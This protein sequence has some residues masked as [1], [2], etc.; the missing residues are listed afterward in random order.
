MT[1]SWSRG[2]TAELTAYF[3]NGSGQLTDA[4]PVLVDILDP[5]DVVVV[6]DATPQHPST[7]TYTYD[8]E[9]PT[10]ATLGVWSARWTGV[11]FSQPVGPTEEPFEVVPAGEV[12][13]QGDFFASVADLAAY[14]D[15]SIAS[16]DPR[17]LLALELATGLIQAGC[18]HRIFR[19]NDDEKVL[20]GT[21]GNRLYLPEPPV[22]GVASVSVGDDEVTTS[23]FSF[24]RGGELIRA[25]FE[26]LSFP[27]DWWDGPNVDVTVVYTHGFDPIPSDIRALCLQ[28]ASRIY[29]GLPGDMARETIGGYS[30]QAGEGAAGTSLTDDEMRI[31]RRY[32]PVAI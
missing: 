9:I 14:L 11:M 6:S 2:A 17:A 19:Y 5:N 24:T 26:D 3:R 31:C 15:E 21:W 1:D 25:P 4:P 10:D 30:Y 8:F 18:K 22:I 20:R 27:L 28:V 12:S 7:G 29:G 16:D 23:G 13:F 32:W